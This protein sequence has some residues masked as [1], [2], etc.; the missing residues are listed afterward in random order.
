MK[1]HTN[2]WGTLAT[3]EDKSHEEYLNL[4]PQEYKD[5]VKDYFKNKK[6]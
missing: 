5:Q 3:C 1:P 2:E 4:I 6:K